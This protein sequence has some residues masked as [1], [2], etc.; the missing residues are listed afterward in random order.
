MKFERHIVV[1]NTD[2]K[3]V[4]LLGKSTDLSHSRL[5]QVM[6][7]G[8]I[9]LT[10]GGKTKRLRRVNKVLQPGDELHLY[11]D[12]VVL[13]NEPDD[14][15]LIADEGQYSIWF[16]PYGM[17][18]QGSR[19]GDH[20][21]INRWVEKKLEPQRPA[22]IVHRLDRAASGLMLIVHRK[23]TAAYFS[24][25][26]QDR[27]ID[28]RYQAIVSGKFS[29]R[30]VF[31]SE[32]EGR[33]AK[34]E[35]KCLYYQPETDRSLLDV[36]IETGRKHQIRRHLSGAG[37]PI[38]GD[39]MYGDSKTSNQ[40]LCLMAYQLCFVSPVTKQQSLYALPDQ[41]LSEFK[42]RMMSQ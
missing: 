9:W 11:Y 34:T 36:A 12:E 40:N 42:L 35:A 26:F 25:L 38:V 23:Q 3:V 16:K 15:V 41:Y 39:R 4:E 29:A 10:R 7:N 27:D 33:M 14:A 13:S 20:C 30:Q 8:A 17:L 19:W 28:K 6:N 1:N 31:E 24:R 32:I 18:S 37:Y 22:F 5:K 2:S 21:A